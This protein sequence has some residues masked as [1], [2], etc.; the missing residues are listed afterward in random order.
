MFFELPQHDPVIEIF[1]DANQEV[2]WKALICEDTGI[3]LE[4][5]NWEPKAE[6]MLMFTPSANTS[7]RRSDAG[8]VM[9]TS[10]DYIANFRNNTQA[11]WV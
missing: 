11:S 9:N 4:I 2:S 7:A 6:Y 10:S 3:L 5:H 8:D 1:T